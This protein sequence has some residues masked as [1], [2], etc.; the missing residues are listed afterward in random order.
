MTGQGHRWTGLGAAFMAAAI[1]RASGMIEF[2]EIAAALVAGASTTMPD[3]TEIPIFR[4]GQRIGSIIPHRTITHWPPI[5]VL[6]IFWGVHDL[7]IVGAL[8]IGAGVGSLWH[9]LG[10]APNPMG[11]PWVL[12]HRRLRIGEKG[13]WRS[14]QHEILM[15]LGFTLLGFGAWFSAGG[16]AAYGLTN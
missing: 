5:W 7:S 12:P 6:L 4:N 10:D 11:I 15:T 16:P 8:A 2:S 1:A 9:I 14:G 3:W 13:L